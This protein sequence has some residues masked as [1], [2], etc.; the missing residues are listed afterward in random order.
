[1]K[2]KI[3]STLLMVAFTLA[4]TSMFVS[5][6]DY[7]DDINAKADKS[8]VSALET[9]LN[10]L[11]ADYEAFKAQ[12]ERDHAN[13]ATWAAH[14]ELKDQVAG[15]NTA[16]NNLKSEIANLAKA[17]D[18]EAKIKAVQDQIDALKS[19]KADQSALDELA[20]KL[21]ALDTKYADLLKEY[22]TVS[23]VD[24]VKADLQ[25]Q[26]DALKAANAKFA[27]IEASLAGKLDKSV[28]DAFVAEL[29]TKYYTKSEI[30]EIVAGLDAKIAAAGNIDA[31]IALVNG[32]KEQITKIQQDMD[33]LKNEI[34]SKL[35]DYATKEQLQ[36]L[37]DDANAEINKKAD[38]A[39]VD[40]IEAYLN[41]FLGVIEDMPEDK[42]ERL[43]KFQEVA[44]QIVNGYGRDINILNVLLT[45]RVTSIVFKPEF[46]A[47]ARPAVEAPALAYQ[48]HI[49]VVGTGYN[50][51]YVYLVNK[52]KTAK[53]YDGA[54]MP[55][56]HY[57]KSYYEFRHNPWAVIADF[58]AIDH[59]TY[60]VPSS[61]YYIINPSSVDLSTAKVSFVGNDVLWNEEVESRGFDYHNIAVAV[62]EKASDNPMVGNVMQVDF[63]VPQWEAYIEQLAK[64]YMDTVP[65]NAYQKNLGHVSTQGVEIALKISDKAS[66]ESAEADVVS[67]WAVVVP[68]MIH[69]QGLADNFADKTYQAVVTARDSKPLPLPVM[70]NC[71]QDGKKHLFKKAA[72]AVD[73]GYTHQVLYN[74]SIDLA[75]FVETH[76]TYMGFNKYNSPNYYISDAEKESVDNESGYGFGELEQTMN[77]ATFK[78]L[79]LKYR[80]T[81]VEYAEGANDTH[82]SAHLQ[83]DKDVESKFYPRSV[84]A[85]GKTIVDETATREALYREPLVKVELIDKLG[86]VIEAGYIKLQIV[87]KITEV[88]DGFLEFNFDFDD[89][90]YVN[91]D[92]AIEREVTW[93]QMEN[94]LFAKLGELGYSKEQFEIEYEIDVPGAVKQYK[95]SVNAKGEAS[96]T[97]DT[98][99]IGSVEYTT[100]DGES[101]E[102]NILKWTVS[103]GKDIRKIY[104]LAQPVDGKSTK[105]LTTYV[106]FIKKVGAGPDL[107]IALTI[108]VG[109]LLFATGQIDNT[110]T[111]TYWFQLNSTKN[112]TNSDGSDA[113]EV[114]V[115]VPVPATSGE[116]KTVGT[117]SYKNDNLLESTEFVKDLH[118]FFLDGQIKLALDNPSK[119]PTYAGKTPQFEFTLPSTKTGNATFDASAS[120]TW[121]VKGISGNTYTLYL[122]NDNMQIKCG[123][124]VIVELDNQ[125]AIHFVEGEIADDI[126]NYKGHKELGELE[127]FTAYLKL[128]IPDACYPIDL[129]GSEWF[130]VRF[131][132]PLTME[133]NG[134]AVV[135]DAPNNWQNVN[136]ADLVK[137]Y[138]W[139]NYEGDPKNSVGANPDKKKF[140]FKYYQVT[141]LTSLDDIVTDA[142]L[143][144]D[145]RPQNAT[146]YKANVAA[147][148]SPL[149]GVQTISWKKIVGLELQYITDA[150]GNPVL[151]YKN[152]GG[153]TG[154]FHI[155]VPVYMQYV[156]GQYKKSYQYTFTMLTVK[157]SVDQPTESKK[158]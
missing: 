148:D 151:Q 18:V 53:E 146:T 76:Y 125:G 153:I 88:P 94:L 121:Q 93:S 17:S 8:A 82:E 85:D 126:L 129:R 11:K 74:G 65:L 58:A 147:G 96:Y 3:F 145:V 155:F 69:V 22:A 31:A 42:A 15:L 98:N 140:D 115:N 107:Y 120:G 105:A 106:R 67:D 131:V 118:D 149:K 104:D 56:I 35:G 141:L 108:P 60:G 10:Q 47:L 64:N 7:D 86:N 55:V 5:C 28:F 12:A 102:T 44:D 138:D 137:V 157:S 32:V 78:Q 6:K 48:P 152:N 113:R 154:D 63:E 109:K 62:H 79:G 89:D 13:F 144:T 143:A 33:D 39:V 1:M 90:E 40:E 135:T 19:G 73:N 84:T 101:R 83:Q 150:S 2:K 114:R 61:A 117:F 59:S 77:E 23:Y 124:V 34:L 9:T 45:K 27:E 80:W 29:G 57:P 49:A 75:A 111:L 26:I 99:P 139:R 81:I 71:Q 16:V 20:T 95:R 97:L 72:D 51:K 14:N 128:T 52:V 50:E 100:M 132:R 158:H 66:E 87:E 110:K 91:C 92:K 41:A 119:F 37:F 68:A 54:E 25:G 134:E 112:A 46:D 142:H 4:S 70:P 123:T 43:K 116:T 103:D 130:N 136:L 127:T 122:S 38:K 30:D 24:A 133:W 156:F 21:A 36:Q